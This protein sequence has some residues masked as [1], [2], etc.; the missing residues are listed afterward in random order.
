MKD[1]P[2]TI[3][4]YDESPAIW[5]E[6]EKVAR[7]EQISSQRLLHDWNTG[8]QPPERFAPVEL[9]DESLRDGIQSPSVT[10]PD[11]QSKKEILRLMNRLGIQWADLGLP[12]AGPRAAAD[13]DALART[14]KDEHLAIRGSCA[15]RTLVADV[16]PISRIASEVGLPLEV[17]AFIGTS[18]IRQFVEDWDLSMMRRCVE[19]SIDYAVKAGL[20]IC[21]VTEDTTRTPPETLEDL[22]LRAIAKGAYRLCL[23][24]TAGHATPDGAKR[25]VEWTLELVERTGSSVLV[26]WHGHNDRGLSIPVTLAAYLA[27]ARRLHGCGLGIGER[28]GNTP[29]DQLLV[30]L[31]LMGAIS[32][33]LSSLTEYC[34]TISRACQVPIPYNYPVLG[35][36]AFR[37]ATGVH[38]AAVIKSQRKGRKDLADLVYSGV[39]ADM[40]GRRQQIEISHM[41]GMSNVQHWLSER[42]LKATKSLCRLILEKAKKG[43]QVLKET[44]IMEIVSSHQQGKGRLAARESDPRDLD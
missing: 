20:P 5:D 4:W 15:A 38:A 36:D 25:L 22:F 44:E 7:E 35:A 34:Q 18:P 19:S 24:D 1:L 3:E 28:V 6:G 11:I 2:D 8:G 10:D 21:L 9:Y 37:T 12:G 31:R 32:T 16:E 41:S 40:V 27:G 42:G 39:P 14:I 13:V 33:D 30:N 29:M 23:C 17:M 43:H 26:D